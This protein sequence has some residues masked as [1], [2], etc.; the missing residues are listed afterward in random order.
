MVRSSSEVLPEPGEL[1]RFSA[2]MPRSASQ[3]RLC[4]GEVVVLGQD[5]LADDQILGARSRPLDRIC[6]LMV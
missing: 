4:C 2:A 1:I 6:Q 3:S 5:R